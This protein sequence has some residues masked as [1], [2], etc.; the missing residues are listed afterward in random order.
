[1]SDVAE[2]QWPVP[3]WMIATVAIALVVVALASYAT[4]P[5]TVPRR[6]TLTVVRSLV[7]LL[8]LAMLSGAALVRFEQQPADLV[9]MLD[10]SAS[11]TAPADGPTADASRSSQPS[12]WQQAVD[13]LTADPNRLRRLQQR[14][15]VRLVPVGATQTLDGNAAV[16]DLAV[17]LKSWEPAGQSSRLGDALLDAVAAQ[18]GQ[19]TAAI[20]MLSDGIVTEGASLSE[21]A[22]AAANLQ[23]PIVAVALGSDAPPTDVAVDEALADGS[24]LLGDT[25]EVRALIRTAGVRQ[26]PVAVRLVDVQSGETLDQTTVLADGVEQQVHSVRLAMQT[27]REGT[28][29][30][31]V[32]AEA[33][34]GERNRDNNRRSLTVEVRDEKLRVLLIQDRPSYEFRFLKQLLERATGLTGAENLVELTVVLQA[35]DPQYADQDRSARRLPPIGQQPL[36]AL[37]VVILSDAAVQSLGSVF[38][39]QLAEAVQRQGVGLVVVAGQLHLPQELEDT[40]L[41]PL[42]PVAPEDV[43]PPPF[44]TADPL[45]MQLTQLGRQTPS[46][47]LGGTGLP[48]LYLVWRATRLRPATRVLMEAVEPAGDLERRWPL[49]LSRLVG[50]GQV[51]L[52]MTDESY[53]MEPFDGTGQMYERYWL[54]TIRQLA[55]GKRRSGQTGATV[56]VDGDRFV[57]GESISIRA[58]VPGGGPTATVSVVAADGQQQTVRMDLREESEY[59]GRIEGLAPGA[60]RAVLT[61]ADLPGLPP[62]DSFVVESAAVEMA[63]LQT[64]LAALRAAAEI[65]GGALLTGAEA[66]AELE[67][68]LPAGE[69]VR[70][71]PLPPR[72]LWNHPLAALLLFGLLCGEWILRRYWGLI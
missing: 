39:E 27:Q 42:L 63:R 31:A 67:R 26:S 34:S 1:M 5:L 15:R 71:R 20:V 7:L 40:A 22:A 23:I 30:L 4:A 24:V 33:V 51:W 49:V 65:S 25:V 2:L 21:A 57:S 10:A 45:A 12:R 32:V 16:D 8:L 18:R 69:A 17:R 11:M 58:R 59:R 61:E 44:P 9:L 28:L 14:Y 3:L 54:Q 36:A 52:Q 37:D 48:P 56:R 47:R 41:D 6:L 53:R 70:V 50:A 60:Y 29:S 43:A 68:R 66:L 64:D 35:G 46:L 13:V 19:S 55:R 62:S 72:P 38:L